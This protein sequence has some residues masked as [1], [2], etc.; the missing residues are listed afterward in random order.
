[1]YA[2]AVIIHRSRPFPAWWLIV[3]GIVVVRFFVGHGVAGLILY[4]VAW[5]GIAVVLVWRRRTGRKRDD[6]PRHIV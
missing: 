3:V 1:V 6:L 4:G 2:G 5:L